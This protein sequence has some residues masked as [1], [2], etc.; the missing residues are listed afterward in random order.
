MKNGLGRTYE[1]LILI[2]DF[3]EEESV[4]LGPDRDQVFEFMQGAI[5]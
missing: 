1:S 4:I 3:K 5:S 2:K